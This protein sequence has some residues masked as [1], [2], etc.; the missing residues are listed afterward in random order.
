MGDKVP[1]SDRDPL[2]AF[3]GDIGGLGRLLRVGLEAVDLVVFIK[4]SAGVYVLVNAAFAQALDRPIEEIIGKKDP[5]LFPPEEARRFREVD[6]RVL[7]GE[8]VRTTDPLTVGEGKRVF[9][10][11]KVPIRNTEG[12]IVGVF[13]FATE[14][15][16]QE[17]LTAALRE[18]EQLLTSVF[19]S[20]Q[21]GITVLDTDLTVRYVNRKMNEWYAPNA[22]LEGKK[23]FACYRNRTEPCDS[24]PTLRAFRSG[25]MERDVVP[26]L[27]GS[28]LE[29]LEL[30][31]YPIRDPDSGEITGAVEFMRD[32]TER[33][34]D[35][36]RTMHLTRVLRA[37]REVN[38]LIT[39]EKDRA[40]LL[41][42]ACELLVETRGYRSA[43]IVLLDGE[44]LNAFY[45]AG[46]GDDAPLLE[47]MYEEG[48]LP[49]C[50]CRALERPEV[51][52]IEDPAEECR[53]CPLLKNASN[54]RELALRLEYGKEVYGL[55]S[56]SV[57]QEYA[58]V[59][60]EEELL[61]ELA[62]DISFAL[63][64]LAI[65]EERRKAEKAPRESEAHYRSIVENSHSGI[66]VIDE[67]RF[68]YA[69]ERL[70]R[71]LGRRLDEILGHD[72][73]EFLD[74]E[75]RNLVVDRYRRRQAGESVPSRYE[76]NVV[77][78]DA[79]KRHVELSSAVIRSPDG[80]TRTIGQILDI[81]ERVQLQERLDAIHELT[82]DLVLL[83][84]EDE[85]IHRTIDATKRLLGM[86]D[87]AAY[88]I[89]EGRAKLLV[90]GYTKEVPERFSEMDL[91]AERGIIPAVAR[92]GEAV[93]LPD[94][95]QDERFLRGRDETRSEFAVPIKVAD[96]IFGV[97]N[98]ESAKEDGFSAED[99]KLLTTLADAAAVALEDI[100]LYAETERLKEFN[101]RIVT[102]LSEGIILE[103]AAETIEYVNPAGAEMLGY[104][105]KDLI[106]KGWK[107]IVPEE[108]RE[109]IEARMKE[110]R[111]GRGERYETS[112]LTRG[113][114]RLP[115]IVGSQP[116]FDDGRFT[117]I[118]SVFTDISERVKTEEALATSYE[119]LKKS[120]DGILKAL[121]AA[122]D[123]RDPYTAGH[124]VRVSKLAV[125]I[126][127][128]MGL[129]PNELEG[130]RYAALVHDIGKLAIPAEILARPT[131][132]NDIEFEIIKEHPAQAYSILQGIEFPWPVA[133]IVLQHHE[134]IDGSGYPKGLKG[135][136]IMPEARIL[137]VADV[138]EAMAS[139]RPYRPAL[140]IRAALT[141]IVR[142]KG[143]LYD[144]E[145]VDACLTVFENG[146]SFDAD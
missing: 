140:G 112:L 138:V 35:E 122:I 146:F 79:G 51:V 40:R 133:E 41:Q 36:R 7:A 135:D 26:G 111:K 1:N 98:A 15:T 124:Q 9:T 3:L 13:G 114:G 89:D 143:K 71:I 73:R 25:R 4:D 64:T 57:P 37:I 103:G 99:R 102:S 42:G 14:I 45:H 5:D 72:F 93:Y 18:R 116:L 142:N 87:C 110:R 108:E 49:E 30:Y 136:E 106:G 58:G 27:P 127:K 137:A 65:E 144:P 23:C 17:E 92:S 48:R 61:R 82:R 56:A 53:D 20:V 75:S 69:N 6:R 2:R 94:V 38:Q 81:T 107:F 128:E 119:K 33:V 113:G 59:E 95:S 117:G 60:E 74:Q 16:E 68:T 139:H 52:M 101:E 105:P 10:T 31:S 84:N 67:Y 62:G 55:I 32:I 132:L 80:K 96:K 88:L 131:K 141:E 43:W 125:A 120:L 104:S 24:C 44:K 28:A 50:A 129:N 78:P 91:S 85:I 130:L 70:C 83:R 86:N 134:R 109:A 22:P 118:L 12:K 34:R 21:D 126:G 76:F 29:W 39:R 97:L 8:T 90:A 121:E 66:F 47:R 100:R 145:V 54:H 123:L 63:H 11:R 19:D 115:V 77:R 46:L